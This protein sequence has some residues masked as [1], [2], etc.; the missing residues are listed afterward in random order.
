MAEDAT[1]LKNNE[2]EIGGELYLR[3]EELVGFRAYYRHTEELDPS[4]VEQIV[5]G[6]AQAIQYILNQYS[7]QSIV[8]L[9]AEGVD[10]LA[11]KAIEPIR[12][13]L[14]A[15][16]E[17]GGVQGHLA[18]I[19]VD[20]IDNRATATGFLNNPASNTLYTLL[21]IPRIGRKILTGVNR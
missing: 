20:E 12:E 21:S 4:A 11:E 15:K 7:E 2:H 19:G 9:A 3:G 16:V 18:A 14:V 1:N 13:G 6:V 8:T 5:S 10:K 17:E